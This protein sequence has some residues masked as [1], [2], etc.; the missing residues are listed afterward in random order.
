MVGASPFQSDQRLRIAE[1]SA[2]SACN[3][4]WVNPSSNKKAIFWS[5]VRSIVSSV[6]RI[7]RKSVQIVVINS[8][9]VGVEVGGGDQRQLVLPI[10]DD[11]FCRSHMVIIRYRRC[12]IGYGSASRITEAKTD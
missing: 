4:S 7:Y 8:S 3:S 9:F 1:Q 2:V 6:T 5:D 12:R 10:G 11:Y